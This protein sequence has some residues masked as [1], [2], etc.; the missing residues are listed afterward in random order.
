MRRQFL[1]EMAALTTCLTLTLA[2]CYLAAWL[3]QPSRSEYGSTWDKYLLEEQNSIDLLFFG[4]SLVYCDVSPE[5]IRNTSSLTSYV[6]AGSEQTIP[7][8][9]YYI[10][11]ACK[12]QS[13]SLIAVD[14][15]GMF[16]HQYQN[17]TQLNIGYMP[18]SENRL[19]ATFEAAEPELVPALLFP[20]YLYHTRWQ[21][22]TPA[23]L[24]ERL[25]PESDKNRGYTQMTDSA[26]AY[27][28]FERPFTSKSRTYA[29]N[30]AYLYKISDFCREH[31]INLFL[32]ISPSMGR[33]P[34][35]DLKTLESDVATIAPD[36]YLN[37]NTLIPQLSLDNEQYWYDTLHLN[38]DGA[39]RF[40]AFL[41]NY[42]IET[43]I[44]KPNKNCR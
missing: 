6:M 31:D 24:V 21:T 39:V 32:Y 25:F 12:T 28:E 29:D 7:I 16:Y 13:P 5:T 42:F 20:L 8:T 41:A 19:R 38:Y 40:S 14:L 27:E 26:A 9:Y 23:N 33:I 34:D 11:E 22:V 36:A 15:T 37:A 30:L 10:R 4:S 17:F 2:G 44:V 18:W 1:W 43:G 35:N 3:L